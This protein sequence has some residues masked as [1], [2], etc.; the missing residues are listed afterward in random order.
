MHLLLIIWVQMFS[1]ECRVSKPD[2]RPAVRERVRHWN[3]K[4]QYYFFQK[5]KLSHWI[6]THKVMVTVTHKCAPESNWYLK[7]QAPVKRFL[8][9]HQSEPCRQLQCNFA[10]SQ[11]V[12]CFM[13]FFLLELK[14][15]HAQPTFNLSP[16]LSAIL[17]FW[18]QQLLIK[19]PLTC[20]FLS[21][22]Q[23]NPN[24]MS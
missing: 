24:N 6:W 3:A 23:G 7:G 21:M 9:P 18:N 14:I 2:K 10:A 19:R 17:H 16:N 12:H 4:I 8:T 13:L 1:L 22:A 20:N 11:F 15:F 5:Y